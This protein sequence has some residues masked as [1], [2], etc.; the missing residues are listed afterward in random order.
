MA[1]R[2]LV[3][4]LFHPAVGW[5]PCAPRRHLPCLVPPR[6]M[7]EVVDGGW[8]ELNDEHHSPPQCTATTDDG[9][10]DVQQLQ[11]LIASAWARLSVDGALE[12]MDHVCCHSLCSISHPC[13]TEA[14]CGSTR[15]RVS[16]GRCWVRARMPCST[17]RR[18][19]RRRRK[20]GQQ[21]HAW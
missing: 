21:P 2:V 4:L 10:S 1:R 6:A 14:P 15:A 3:L 18:S 16:N 17:M 19:M 5:L 11:A 20:W 8:L 7:S 13:E 9:A 12:Y